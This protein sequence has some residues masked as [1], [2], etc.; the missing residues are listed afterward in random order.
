M[1]YRQ[2]KTIR[3]RVY[4]Y[5]T[6]T[7]RIGGNSVKV[8]QVCLGTPEQIFEKCTADQGVDPPVKESHLEFGLPAAFY[9]QV[10]ELS[11]IPLINSYATVTS[12]HLDVGQYLVLAAIN[13]V[14]QP[15]RRNTIASWYKGTVLPS[16]F[17]TPVPRATGQRFW[18]AMDRFPVE[19]IPCVE[20]DL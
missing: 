17:T 9:Q 16:L 18:D 20:Q 5:Y 6:E 15:R 11:L 13:L 4:Y 19:A 12:P 8:Q 7:K 14:R 2:K 1:V 3:G 10:L